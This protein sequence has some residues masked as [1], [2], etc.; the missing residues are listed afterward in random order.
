VLVCAYDIR[1]HR[2]AAIAEML[3]VHPYTLVE[4]RLRRRA[5]RRQPRDR[6]LSTAARLFHR[7]GIAATGV[8]RVSA[9]AG[10]AKAT[11]YRQ[12]RSKEDLVLAWIRDP[13]TRWFD[14]VFERAERTAPTP[15]EVIPAVFD[16]VAD[17]LERDGYRGCPYLHT[18]AE[19]ADI[20]RDNRVRM[21]ATAY[22]D[23]VRELLRDAAA[24]AGADR[25]TGDRLHIL[26]TGAIVLAAASRS[27]AP[28][29]TAREDSAQHLRRRSSPR[30]RSS[31]RST[32]S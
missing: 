7:H 14:R 31:R 29:E 11:F 28:I 5:T 13:A 18:I 16:A 32:P 9:E 21:A 17:W 2:P 25:A 20:D 26:L 1:R 24:A 8:D 6:I 23:E 15:E 27:S 10:V 12:Y 4:G 22:L 3:D 30:P 19:L